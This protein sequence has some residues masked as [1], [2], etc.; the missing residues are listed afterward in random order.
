MTP[1]LSL[2]FSRS[3]VSNSF[4]TPWAVA[5]E[6]P[7]SMGFPRQQYGGEL[8]FPSGNAVSGYILKGNKNRVLKRHLPSHVTVVLLIIAKIWKQAVDRLTDNGEFIYYIHVYTHTH[9]YM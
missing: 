3:V 9:I 7:L 4:A 1:F 6:A 2:L 5:C 8:L